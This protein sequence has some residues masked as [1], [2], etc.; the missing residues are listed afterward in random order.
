MSKPQNGGYVTVVPWYD[1]A[2][3]AEICI[4]SAD[5]RSEHDYER[6]RD[7]ASR[8]IGL[9]LRQGQAIE[10]VTVHPA[11]YRAWLTLHAHPDSLASRQRFVCE[12]AT[13]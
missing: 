5:V 10:I 8:A 7:Q 4:A 1:R 3:F 2:G 9:L 6:W 11:D 12:L 13:A